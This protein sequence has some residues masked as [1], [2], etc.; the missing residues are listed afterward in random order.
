MVIT[1]N[2]GRAYNNVRPLTITY[3]PFGYADASIMFEL[4]QTKV[5]VAVTL[6]NGVPQFL[7]GKGTGWLTAEYAMLP[8]STRMRCMRDSMQHHR[9]NRSV[10][11]SRFIGRSL[12]SVVD[13]SF[14]GERTIVVD[15]DV[16][17]ADG[18]TRVACVS[19]ASLVLTLAAKRWIEAGVVEKNFVNDSLVA[20]SVGM[21]KGQVYLDLT[22]VE[23]NE[24]DADFNFILTTNGDVV[25]VQ[26]TAEKAPVSW[27]DFEHFKTLAL[28]GI[29]Q[30]QKMSACFMRPEKKLEKKLHSYKEGRAY[31]PAFFSL[32]NR[33]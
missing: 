26:G 20:I 23:D 11:I 9:N 12:R 1:R 31:K 2:D 4:G 30:L 28:M 21:V 25:E 29:E 27:E 14:L 17:Q 18:G 13:L 22:Q 7:K 6:Q 33:Q 8:T 5:M 16:I 10:E 32:A 3:D 24:A 19:A 15:C